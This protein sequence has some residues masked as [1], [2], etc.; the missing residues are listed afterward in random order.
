[1]ASTATVLGTNE[2][3]SF[4]VYFLE[5]LSFFEE[6]LR[7]VQGLFQEWRSKEQCLLQFGLL[8]ILSTTNELL[9]TIANTKQML[10][11]L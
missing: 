7:K 8:P 2:Y 9:L 3:R 10:A 4:N 6:T 5:G 1:M 11:A